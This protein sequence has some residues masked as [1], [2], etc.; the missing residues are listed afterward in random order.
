MSDNGNFSE[1]KP[2]ASCLV[3]AAIF[4][5]VFLVSILFSV[6]A[7]NLNFSSPN[8][9]DEVS[10]PPHYTIVPD[11]SKAV[12]NAV[13]DK[14]FTQIHMGEPF[15]KSGVTIELLSID[16]LYEK[17]S[18]AEHIKPFPLGPKTTTRVRTLGFSD[19]LVRIKMKVSHEYL[20]ADPITAFVQISFGNN[21]P[22][23]ATMMNTNRNEGRTIE[24]IKETAQN[25]KNPPKGIFED[26]YEI[27]ARFPEEVI[28]SN[29]IV[30][31]LIGTTDVFYVNKLASSSKSPKSLDDC[32]NLYEYA[33]AYTIEEGAEV[34]NVGASKLM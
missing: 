25:L 2:L 20:A 4:I 8:D 30:K 26:T 21:K 12:P 11:T 1:A 24:E 15:E 16:C 27:T 34:V 28:T 19:P 10:E 29:T 31:M 22:L 6:I 18:T 3:R 9:E 17:Q 13:L 33:T 23:K 5:G 32:A 7:S 14:G